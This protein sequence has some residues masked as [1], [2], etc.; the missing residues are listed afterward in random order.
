M[1]GGREEGEAPPRCPAPPARA[2]AP[3]P[4][5]GGA[6][7]ASHPFAAGPA[8]GVCVGG[9]LCAAPCAA[10]RAVE[11]RWGR[12]RASTPPL[13]DG[14]RCRSQAVVTPKQ[15]LTAPVSWWKYKG[16]I[17]QPVRATK[18]SCGQPLSGSGNIRWCQSKP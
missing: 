11:G 1:G 10:P 13:Q 14:G 3:P 12:L 17:N 9:G 4:A 5:G 18:N 6:H 16:V 8:T 2:R 7:A 15:P